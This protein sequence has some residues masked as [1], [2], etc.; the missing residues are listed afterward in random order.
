MASAKSITTS[1]TA[2]NWVM[3]GLGTSSLG[4]VTVI[5]IGAAVTI[6]I[7][8]AA[9]GDA[10]SATNTCMIPSNTPVDFF[11]VDPSRLAFKSASTSVPVSIILGGNP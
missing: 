6:A 8:I 9:I 2:G 3:S 10:T 7:D 1:G 5:P 11:G 4:P